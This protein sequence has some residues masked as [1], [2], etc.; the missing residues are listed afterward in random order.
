MRQGVF[1][2]GSAVLLALACGEQPESDPAAA[3]RVEAADIDAVLASGALLLDVRTAE[4]LAEHGTI[5]G[6]VHI[7]IDELEGRLDELPQGVPIL[8]A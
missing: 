2:L 1:L 6:F 8:T 5:E 7:P 3:P 4:E